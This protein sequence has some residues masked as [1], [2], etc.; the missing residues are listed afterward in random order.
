[1]GRKQAR[2]FSA[3]EK[4]RILEEERGSPRRRSRRRA[5]RSGH[6][7]VRPGVSPRP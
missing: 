5:G 6:V 2:R 7:P 4:L 3:E 1:M